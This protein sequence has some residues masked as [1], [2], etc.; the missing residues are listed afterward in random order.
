MSINLLGREVEI[1]EISEN[2]PRELLLNILKVKDA[3]HLQG[4]IKVRVED[5]INEFVLM[6]I[7]L[8]PTGSSSH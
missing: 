1:F 8:F 5:T 2:R 6:V 7:H 4:H 3:S